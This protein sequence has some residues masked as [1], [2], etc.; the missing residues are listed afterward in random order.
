MYG[1]PPG[2]GSG[3]PIKQVYGGKAAAS[4]EWGYTWMCRQCPFIHDV[5][6]RRAWAAAKSAPIQQCTDAPNAGPRFCHPGQEINASLRPV[7]STKYR[8]PSGGMRYMPNPLAAR[9]PRA[10]GRGIFAP[11]IALSDAWKPE[12]HILN[13]LPC[14]QRH[15]CYTY[16]CRATGGNRHWLGRGAR[17]KVEGR[18]KIRSRHRRPRRRLFRFT[19]APNAQGLAAA[20]Q[21]PGGGMP[22]R[23][24]WKLALPRAQ[25]YAAPCSAGESPNSLRLQLLPMQ[26]GAAERAASPQMRG[27]TAPSC[28]RRCWPRRGR[29]CTPGQAPWRCSRWRRRRSGRHRPSCPTLATMTMPWTICSPL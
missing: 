5:P 19:T 10:I 28:C 23:S 8:C 1:T 3:K 13:A 12:M 17:A 2:Q 9:V 24:R 6:S 20:P 7:C 16:A 22:H 18:G 29:A 26:K 27:T 21:A 14:V 11:W 4:K 15:K 25:Q